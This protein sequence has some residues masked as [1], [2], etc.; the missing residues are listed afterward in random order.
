MKV[1]NIT[2][3]KEISSQAMKADTFMAR[4]FGLIPRESLGAEEGLWLEPCNSI[5][6]CFMRFPIDAVFMD[7][8]LKVIKILENFKPWRFSPFISGARGVLELPAGRCAGR[9]SLGDVL[10]FR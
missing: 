3:Q 10:E 5:H 4:L 6:M 7:K 8:N 9:I 2:S 1:F